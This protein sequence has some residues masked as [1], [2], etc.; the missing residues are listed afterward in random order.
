MC[1]IRWIIANNFQLDSRFIVSRLMQLLTQA[2][3]CDKKII[4]ISIFHDFTGRVR[5]L[6]G[7]RIYN[8]WCTRSFSSAVP[9]Q[10]APSAVKLEWRKSIKNLFA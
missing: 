4:K 5:F 6:N 2:R 8:F 1:K 9:S 10:A 7:H 3:N